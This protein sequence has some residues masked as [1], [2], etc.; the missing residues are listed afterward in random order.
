ME[1][2]RVRLASIAKDGT[3]TEYT[4]DKSGP[5]TGQNTKLVVHRPSIL[6]EGVTIV[7]DIS[8]MDEVTIHGKV[9]GDVDCTRIVVGETGSIKGELSGEELSISGSI[10][11]TV[12]GE[13]V[14][15]KKS[16]DVNGDI[17]H[18][19]VAMEAGTEYTGKLQRHIAGSRSK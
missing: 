7:G 17:H 2:E 1:K 12:R 9:V 5:Q 11:G 13:W 18:H 15:L 4:R 16:A 14:E 3:R 8:S 6:T 19:Y 10:D